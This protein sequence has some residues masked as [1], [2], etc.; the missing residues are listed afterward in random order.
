DL[1]ATYDA[2]FCLT[3]QQALLLGKSETREASPVEEAVLHV[4]TPLTKLYTGKLAVANAS[5]VLECFGGAGYVEAT[6]LPALLRDAQVLSIWEGTTNVIS[7]EVIRAL[8]REDAWEP[9]LELV[10][11]STARA[12]HPALRDLGNK[13]ESDAAAALSWAREAAGRSRPLLEA[14]ARRF[15]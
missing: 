1:S 14:G 7:L 11:R 10:R 6:G 2:A 15:A 4:L 3:L 9:L 8:A 12:S 5:E 13:A